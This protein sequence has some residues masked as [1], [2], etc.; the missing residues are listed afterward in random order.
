MP[1]EVGLWRNHGASPENAGFALIFGSHSDAEPDVATT[2]SWA[3]SGSDFT[4]SIEIQ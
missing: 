4:N 1:A 3:V 2:M